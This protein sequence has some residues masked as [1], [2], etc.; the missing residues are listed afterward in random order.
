M[1]LIRVIMMR[2]RKWPVLVPLFGLLAF[3]VLAIVL[4]D[5][6]SLRTTPV[7][8]RYF[9]LRPDSSD[10]YADIGYASMQVKSVAASRHIPVPEVRN[11]MDAF[12][13]GHDGGIGRQRVDVPGLNAALDERWRM[14]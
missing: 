9:H 11:L 1:V 5:R 10:A 7:D 13:I 3:I 8:L 4:V 6:Q 12:T 14:Q 2:E